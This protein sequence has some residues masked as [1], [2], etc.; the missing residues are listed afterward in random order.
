[1]TASSAV[2]AVSDHIQS[3][4]R[5]VLRD[6]AVSEAGVIFDMVEAGIAVAEL[7]ANALD[8][9]ADVGAVA[10][11]SVTGNEVLAVDEVVDFTISDIATGPFGEKPDDLELGQA[12]IDRSAGPQRPVGIAA[13]FEPTDSERRRTGGVAFGRRPY[14][15]G[16][17]FEAL[18]EDRQATRFVN[19]ID[20][21]AFERRLFI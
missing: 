4:R 8:K 10:L 21:A 20:S 14:A 13:Q 16:D 1:M 2:F 17:Q 15:F 18:Q 3:N 7:L 11:G 19:K 9:G 12:E 6:P 5:L